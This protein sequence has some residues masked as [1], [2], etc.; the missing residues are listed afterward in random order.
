MRSF[1]RVVIL[2]LVDFVDI[3]F[4]ALS[5]H[6]V[7]DWSLCQKQTYRRCGSGPSE[8]AEVRQAQY[9]T[10]QNVPHVSSRPSSD[11]NVGRSTSKIFQSNILQ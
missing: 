8:R 5:S 3:L 11:S 4:D 7:I 10:V 9:S 6:C 2:L 1:G